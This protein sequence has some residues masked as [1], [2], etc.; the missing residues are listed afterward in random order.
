MKSRVGVVILAVALA[1]G[2]TKKQR[3]AEAASKQQAVEPLTVKTVA[4]ESRSVNKTISVTGSIQADESV[5][6]SFEV[7]GRVAAIYVDFGQNVRKGQVLAELDRQELALQVERAKAALSQALARVGLQPGQE[8]VRPESTPQVRQAQAQMEDARSKYESAAKLVK[9]GDISQ[10]RYTETEKTFRSRQ[11]AFEAA[12]DEMRTQLAAVE[13]LRADLKLAEKRLGDTVIR[14]PFNGA[15]TQKSISPGQYVKDNTTVLTIVKTDPLRLRVE[16]P[17]AATAAVK[18]G[19]ALEFVTDAAPGIRFSAVV[20]ELNPSLDVRSR[21]LTAEARLIK[22]DPRLRPGMFVQVDL[23]LQKNNEIV[24]VPE[25][26]IYSV[27]GLSKL[28]VIRGGKAV[29]VRITPGQKVDR[30]VEVPREQIM[31]GDQVAVSGLTQ[32]V[33]GQPVRLSHMPAS[34]LP[35]AQSVAD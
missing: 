6:M 14:A 9:S 20:R 1:A 23:V 29:E 4:A 26:A 15:V 3:N 31:P 8:D 22:N 13:G 12:R 7:A 16:V 17:E 24:V 33:N 2:C 25:Q 32:L 35:S 19:S 21:T 11:A 10:E 18:P 28:F 34:K 27:A 30:W 5:N